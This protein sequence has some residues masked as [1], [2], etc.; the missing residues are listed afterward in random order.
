LSPENDPLILD[1]A[2]LHPHEQV[3]P[4]R[5]RELK[6]QLAD[7]GFQKDPIIVEDKNLIVIDGH[8]RIRA[9]RA[10]GYSRVVAHKIDYLED[11]RIVL[12]TW[13]PV[14]TGSRTE[15]IKALHHC[16][17]A[18]TQQNGRLQDPV[19]IINDREYRLR[20]T[21]RTIMDSLLGR[22]KIEYVPDVETAKKLSKDNG[23][24]GAIIFGSISKEDVIRAALSGAVL[25]PKTTQHIVP[26]K[27]VDW[28]IPLE[29]LN[30][31]VQTPATER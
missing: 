20:A 15:L 1:I 6:K 10:L 28:F 21:R 5:L 7:D 12:K 30:N 13:Y 19:L 18:S 23:Y 29:R 26:N 3:D 27:P 4:I 8:H 16:L 31:G 2:D 22:F 17:E 11:D 9:L 25:P 14:I 24:G